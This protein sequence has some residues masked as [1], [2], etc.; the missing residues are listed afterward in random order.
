MSDKDPTPESVEADEKQNENEAVEAIKSDINKEYED[1]VKEEADQKIKSETEKR[2]EEYKAMKDMG[3]V[4]SKDVEARSAALE[5]E[6]KK[7][8]EEMTELRE[9]LLRKKAQGKI[10]ASEQ[11]KEEDDLDKLYGATLK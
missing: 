5:A 8:R 9:F 4:T 1:T 7:L 2:A 11:E 6:N 3:F 10:T